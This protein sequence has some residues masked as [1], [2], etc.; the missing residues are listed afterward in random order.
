MKRWRPLIFLI[1]YF[2]VF[3]NVPAAEQNPGNGY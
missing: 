1:V 3:V 2:S